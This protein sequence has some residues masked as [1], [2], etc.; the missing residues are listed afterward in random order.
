MTSID[1]S[2]V[3]KRLSERA[4]YWHGSVFP[5][6]DWSLGYSKP[7]KETEKERK[8][9]EF[10]AKVQKRH[11]YETFDY[12]AKRLRYVDEIHQP[13]SQQWEDA[14]MGLSNPVNS[15]KPQTRANRGS[16]GISSYGKKM[17]RSGCALLQQRY[18]KKR[19]S[20]LTLT[21]PSLPKWTEEIVLTDMG[22]W[23]EIV[24]QTLQEFSRE[25]KRKGGSGNIVG[26]VEI[27]E[28]RYSK[29]GTVSPHLHLVFEGHKG[30]Y[31]YYLKVGEPQRIWQRIVENQLRK[32]G[33][34]GE[35]DFCQ[36]TRIESIH[37]DA[38]NYMGKYMSKG[39]KI[40]EKIIEDGKGF[41]LPSSW[42]VCSAKIKKVIK[43]YSF[44]MEDSMKQRILN[45]DADYIEK[46]FFFCNKVIR[47]W[48]GDEVSFGYCGRFKEYSI[49]GKELE[50]M[51]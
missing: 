1:L 29:Y 19:L 27:Q 3:N 17:V 47:E 39:G 36:S 45:G 4:C 22:G 25:L 9:E 40:V 41:L 6:G 14:C 5:S 8:W 31:D 20:F 44:P 18:G 7:K 16:K 48:K 33:L 49:I 42:W 30:N 24:R 2:K 28:E 46:T 11:Y 43:L 12:G 32:V 10:K 21:M 26:V 34:E 51:L 37:K 15:H 38:K 13:G 35:I 50:E 23:S